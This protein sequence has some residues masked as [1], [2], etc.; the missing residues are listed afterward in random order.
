MVCLRLGER[1]MSSRGRS[2]CT[3]MLDTFEHA[4]MFGV[5]Q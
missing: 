4:R 5:E 2:D 1:G 3:R